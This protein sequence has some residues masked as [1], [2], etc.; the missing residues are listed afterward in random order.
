MPN[1]DKQ[2]R[3]IWNRADTVFTQEFKG[4]EITIP[5]HGSIVRGRRWT[6]DFLGA[7]THFDPEFPDNPENIK[8]LLAED[9]NDGNIEEK[10]EFICNMCGER[11]TS[12][13]ALGGHT[14]KKHGKAEPAPKPA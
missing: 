13:R 14:G 9:V 11:F 3:R 6:V 5:P 12:K 7:P 4:E 2:M 10:Q 8:N 1:R